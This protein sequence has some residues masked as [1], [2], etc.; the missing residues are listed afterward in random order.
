PGRDGH[1][2]AHGHLSES[3]VRSP[4]HAGAAG[5]RACRQRRSD[6]V[7][8]VAGYSLTIGRRLL[9][10]LGQAVTAVAPA[11]R[12]ALIADSNVMPLYGD[13]ASNALGSAAT[14]RITIEAG[15]VHKT[16]DAWARATDEMLAA[17]MGRDTTVVAQPMPA[18]S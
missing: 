12:F 8:D 16:R 2:A 6:L 4:V 5:Q 3:I 18:A 14:V 9:D 15:E 10:Q 11:H 1:S 7:I 17:G 13:R